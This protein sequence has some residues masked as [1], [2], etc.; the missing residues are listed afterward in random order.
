ML[1][2]GLES[3]CQRVIGLMKKGTQKEVMG[4]IL[5]ATAA[6]GIQNMIL[7][8]VGFPTETREEAFES[9]QFLQDHQPQ[10]KFALAGQFLLEE[11][12]PIYADPK[13]FNLTE[14]TPLSPKS[15]L[16]I[17]Y[18][19]QTGSG[20]SAAEA[21]EIKDLINDSTQGLHS[22]DFLN[23]AHLLLSKPSRSSAVSDA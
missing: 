3:A 4:R 8:F 9:M 20:M 22:E 19:Y 12:S 2:F 15:D 23:R 10:V 11:S 6:A 16:G 18:G 5:E 1:Y 21:G 14:V 7:Y 13:A 17:I